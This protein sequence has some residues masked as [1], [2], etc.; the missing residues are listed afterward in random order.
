MV[1]SK[2]NSYRLLKD[3]KSLIAPFSIK[4]I[5]SVLH[6]PDTKKTKIK[7]TD[8]WWKEAIL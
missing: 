3:A 1:N 2:I 7:N 6:G 5:K 4:T 8:I